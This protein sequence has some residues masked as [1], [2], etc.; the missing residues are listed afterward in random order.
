MNNDFSA[1]AIATIV[2]HALDA[3]L[4]S[5]G[6]IYGEDGEPTLESWDETYDESDAT[7]ELRAE[8]FAAVAWLDTADIGEDE[9]L[10]KY[11]DAA[12]A[13]VEALG[14]EQFGHDMTLTRNHHGA[15]FWDRGLGEI[16][17]VLTEWAHGLGS[18]HVFHGSGSIHPDKWEGMFHAE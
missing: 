5:E 17:D 12:H 2:K 14:L 6:E 18:L 9:T 15:G 1:D 8:L 4:W 10:A 3:L 7:D 13:Y 16:G 11:R